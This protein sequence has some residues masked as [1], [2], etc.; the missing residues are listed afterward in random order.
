MPSPHG[1]R[2]ASAVAEGLHACSVAAP[3]PQ[4]GRRRERPKP[5]PPEPAGRRPQHLRRTRP[6]G[7]TPHRRATCISSSRTCGRRRPPGRRRRTLPGST[8]RARCWKKPARAMCRRRPTR[9]P[10]CR[11]AAGATARRAR[12]TA[13]RSPVQPARR[14]AGRLCLPP[15]GGGQGLPARLEADAEGAG[16]ALAEPADAQRA[17]TA[18]ARA[19]TATLAAVARDDAERTLRAADDW[20]RG[21]G[22]TLPARAWPRR[23]TARTVNPDLAPPDGRAAAAS[24]ALQRRFIMPS[25]AAKGSTERGR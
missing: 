5:V 20:M 10:P 8:P 19:A 17:H 3:G 7:A 6:C 25:S 15:D 12:P 9:P 22:F 23:G 2:R 16:A 18:A 1:E 21:I 24:S 13:R 14:A 11:A 4:P